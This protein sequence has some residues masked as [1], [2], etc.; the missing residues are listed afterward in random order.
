MLT[1]K[2]GTFQIEVIDTQVVPSDWLNAP[3]KGVIASEKV[4]TSNTNTYVSRRF[5][6]I[7]HMDDGWNC[8]EVIDVSGEKMAQVSFPTQDMEQMLNENRSDQLSIFPNYV[9]FTRLLSS[10]CHKWQEPMQKLSSTTIK[11]VET[12]VKKAIDFTMP[13]FPHFRDLIEQRLLDFISTCVTDMQDALDAELR[14]EGDHPSTLNHYLYDTLIKLR[15]KPLIQSFKGMSDSNGKI[16]VDHAL[17]VLKNFGVGLHSNEQQEAIEMQFA[18]SAYIKVVKKRFIDAV[19]RIIQK[20]LLHPISED[21][22]SGI[23][24]SDEELEKVLAEPTSIMAKRQYLVAKHKSLEEAEKA[25]RA[26]L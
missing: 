26:Q 8:H 16:S 7:S 4:P 25:F 19:P 22:V 6:C 1:K 23:Q 13:P 21:M 15:T 5:K 10:I 24:L 18:L 12:F 20:R 3:S 9:V 17:S 11:K 2:T 14:L